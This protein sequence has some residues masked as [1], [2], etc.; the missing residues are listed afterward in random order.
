MTEILRRVGLAS[1]P[2][3]IKVV[4]SITC[5][6]CGNGEIHPTLMAEYG[7]KV[8]I[9]TFK[10]LID[11]ARGWESQCLVCSGYYDKDLNETPENHNPELGWFSESEM[12]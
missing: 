1:T 11:Q 4:S 8:L 7:P 6:T 12:R 5:P 2:I 10:V 9:R 3:K